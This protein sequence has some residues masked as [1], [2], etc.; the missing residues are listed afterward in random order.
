MVICIL[1]CILIL[2]SIQILL[3]IFWRKLSQ[4][5]ETKVGKYKK[6]DIK[7]F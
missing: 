6:S 7:K 2:L 3:D 5:K 1:L 4:I